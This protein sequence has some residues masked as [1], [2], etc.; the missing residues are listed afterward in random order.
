MRVFLVL[1][2]INSNCQWHVGLS[3]IS[4]VLKKGGHDV[5]LF[6]LE[7]F[8]EQNHF[9]LERIKEFRP[10]VIGISSNSHQ[11]KYVDILA[12]EIKDCVSVPIFLGGVHT[13][14]NPENIKELKYVDGVCIGEGE[15]AFLELVNAINNKRNLTDIKNFWIKH[16][17]EVIKNTSRPL[18]ENLNFLPFPDRSIFNYFKEKKTKKVPRF[19]FSRGCPFDCAYCCNHAI[20][21]VYKDL[22]KYVRF[23]TVNMAIAE[24]EAELQKYNFS[25][26]KLDDDTFSLNKSWLKEFCNTIAIKNWNLTFECN[27]RPGTIDAEAMN[28]L[29]KGGCTLVKI[30]IETGNEAL[31][32]EVLNRKFSNQDIIK[33]FK[34]AKENGIKTF[35]FNMIGIPGENRTTIKETIDLNAK[36]KP[37]F[38][39]VTIFYPYRGTVLGDECFRKGYVERFSEDSYMEKSSLKLPGISRHLIEKSAKNFKFK[40]Y[41]HY[42][43][44]KALKEAILIVK[45]FILSNFVLCFVFKKARILV[46]NIKKIRLTLI[47]KMIK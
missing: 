34:I 32:K 47:R 26:F 14:L 21:K 25:H 40:V 9:L 41:W 42:D 8:H 45:M 38:M 23:R 46:K 33:T 16:G 15:E 18:I 1:L 31:R 20:K 24:I 44:K 2:K 10:G 28:A 37:D 39:Q 5:E 22:G 17:G 43:K 27:V 29:K 12:K 35:S 11:F 6:E 4:A 30:G 36:I 3:Y 19:I 13:T 7:N